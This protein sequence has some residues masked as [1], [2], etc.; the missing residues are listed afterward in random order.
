MDA[1]QQSRIVHHHRIDDL[2]LSARNQEQFGFTDTLTVTCLISTALAKRKRHHK[3][4]ARFVNR[5]GGLFG[6][7]GLKFEVLWSFLIDDQNSC[8]ALPN[9]WSQVEVSMN[10]FWG[11]SISISRIFQR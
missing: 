7:E 9:L 11:A 10:T 6:F 5:M 2:H 1:H 3:R 4:L 8:A